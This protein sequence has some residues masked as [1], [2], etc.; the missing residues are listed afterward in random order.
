MPNVPQLG[1]PTVD[2]VMELSRSIV[3][4][5]FTGIA[6]TQGRILT[7]SA[8]F[9]LPYLNSAFRK[10]QRRLRNEGVTFPIRDGVLLLALPPVVEADPSKFVS[11]GFTG[12]NNGTTMFASPKLPG[13]CMQ[14]SVVRQRV[15]GSNLQFTPMVQAQEGLASGYQNQWMGEWE[16]RGYQIFM[17]G[18]LQTTDL[19]IR[20]L[21][22]QPP[23]NIQPD[24]F[25]TTSIYIIDSQDALA[26]LIA[27]MYG[28]A[29]G[30][31]EAQLTKVANDATEAIEEMAQEYVRRQQTVT[32]QRISYQGGGSNNST[33]ASL[34]TTGVAS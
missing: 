30:A 12:Y 22:G 24:E 18:S 15:T 4:D 32:Y 8:P 31:N 16:W 27:G 13:D 34:G 7:N 17:N 23:I 21:S 25:A 29:R 19:M 3:N 10:L 26:N 28:T 5:T 14:V 11:V 1:F 9:T 33:N 2:E 20:Y 6:G